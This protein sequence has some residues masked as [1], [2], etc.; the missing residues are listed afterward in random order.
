MMQ[1]IVATSLK[2]RYLVVFAAAALMILGIGQIRSMPVD[3]FPEFAPPRVEIQT[4]CL[5]LSSTEV[6]QLVTVPLEEVFNGMPGLA[7][8][9]S[10]SVEQLSSI[11]LIFE[12]ETD[13]MQARQLVA[14]RLAIAT[15]TLPTWAAPPFMLPPLSSTARTMKIGISSKEHSVIDLS[16]LTYWKIREHLLRV[17]GVA[18]VAMWGERI[19]MP[20]VRVDPKR[21]SANGVTLD[22]VMQATSDTLDSGMMRYSTGATIGRG[23]FLETPNQRLAIQHVQPIVTPDDLARVAIND[24]K[25]S[26]GTPLRLGDVADVVVDTWPMIG[27]AVVNDGPGLLLIVEKFPWANS[28]EVTNG[29]EAA[30]N[31]MRPGLPGVDIDT[32]IFRPATFIEVALENLTQSLLIG[33][34]LV[35]LILLLFLWDW[36]VALISAT[37]IPLTVVITLLVLSF[38]GTTINVMVL[39][40]LVIAIGAVVDDAIVDVENIV[41]RLRLF[42]REGNNMPT[43][44]VVLMASVEVRAAIIYASL[45]EMTALLPVFF[46]QGLSG[47][48]FKPLAQAYV[49]AALVS[50]LVALTVTPALILI[51]LSNAPLKDNVSPIIP[52][53]HRVYDR[54]LSRTIRA[55][56][57]V[58]A[59]FT[60]TMVAGLIVWP[61]LGQELLPS[62]KERDFLMHW[63][64]K[65]GTSHPEMVRISTLA[66]QELRSIPG[67]RNCGSHIGQALLMDEV[68][69]VYFGENWVSVDPSVDYDATLAKIQAL[70]DGYPGLQ[71]DVQTYLKERIREVLTGSSHPI[72]IRIYGQ[73][74][75]I[76]RAKAKE[77]EEKLSK[78]PGLTDL[79]VELLT[80][81]PQVQI[82]VDLA[83]AKQY[84]LKPGDVRRAAAYLVA[85]EEA[86][87]L[88]TANRTFDVNVW[89]TPESRRN[90][91]DIQNL[92]IDTPSGKQVRL[93]DVA[94]ISIVATPNAV[95]RESLARRINVDAEVKGRD[96]GSA[97]AD[98]ERTLSEI[99]FPIGYHPV[100][101]G[102]Y[103]ERKA[104]ER[105]ILIA[106]L[107]AALVIFGLLRVSLGSWRLATMSFL[108]LPV[109]LV[110]G[111]LAAYFASNGILSLGSLV[112]FLTILGVAARNGIMLISHYQHLE[113]Q[114]GEPFGPGLVLRGARERIAPIM[115]TALTAGLAL[116]P[117]VIAGNIPGHEIEHPMAIVILGGL[118]TS[119]L[120]NLFIVPALYLR[121]GR[122]RG[123]IPESHATGPASM[124]A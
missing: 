61:L 33:A 97:V 68:Y 69:G 119:T 48:F 74:L 112:G 87:D 120:V 26:D 3:V 28:L 37:I 4:P 29:V 18:N 53:L 105:S 71:R 117:L 49:V 32:T 62:F 80:D 65:P 38:F 2:F 95:N 42:R 35:V 23:G 78:I 43:A 113:E 99:E 123:S 66:C 19:Q 10:K 106:G 58:Y 91:T 103:A 50:P 51:L 75:E 100:L 67:V 1:W 108:S 44:D 104:A 82:E 46:M 14:E 90:L 88:H 16:M 86:G 59:T 121:F 93:A 39:A 15:P 31:E 83:K 116:V 70:V 30:I 6:E 56:R 36:R 84:G 118:I 25:K 94:T 73:D 85:G 11:V 110:G 21:L 22:E 114:E 13:L 8:M 77:V 7:V 98:V 115:M 111:V 5:G 122:R 55:P 20:Q 17:R 124:S 60:G 41:R 24:K 9:R 101:I 89:S 54:L 76:L 72:V 81:I 27:D 34:G 57:R 45:I 92:L 52:W 63:I 79:H 47:A 12:P 40:G 109:A 96:L 64:T 107:A 102:E